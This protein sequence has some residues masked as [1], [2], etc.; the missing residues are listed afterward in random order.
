MP[1]AVGASIRNHPV[2][3]LL[4]L[5]AILYF[6]DLGRVELSV[7]DEARSGMIARDMLEGNFLLPRTPDGYLV[8]KPPAYYATCALLGATFGVN[9][10][11]LRGVSAMAALATLA[12]TA[13]IVLFF[14]RPRAAALAVAALASNVL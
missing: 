9:E 2:A 7:T 11:T 4:G 1:F 12:A 6:W 10:W 3:W 8:E 14:G 5:V 13:W